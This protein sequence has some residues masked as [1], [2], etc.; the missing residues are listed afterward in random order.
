MGQLK[1]RIVMVAAAGVLAVTSLAGCSRTLNNDAVVA[2]VG[3]DEVKLGVANFYAR[4]Q[5]AQMETYYGSMLGGGDQMWTQEIEEGKTYE[6]STKSN[7]IKS[8]ENMYLLKQHAGDYD[9]ELTDKEKKAID[10][11]ADKFLEDNTL[12]GKDAV[13]GTKKVVKE[14][15]TL[16]T[17]QQKMDAPLKAGVD[18]EVSD[19][20]AA[21]KSMQY[22]LFAYTKQD[23]SGQSADMTD[24]EKAAQKTA[25]QDFAEKLKNSEDKNLET[26]AKAAGAEVQTATFDGESTS[27]NADLVKAADALE[28]EGDVTDAVETDNGIYIAKVTSFLD[29]EATDIKKQ[30]IVE[31]RKQDQYDATIKKWRKATDIKVKK[32]VWKKVSF[33][34]QGVTIKQSEDTTGSDADSGE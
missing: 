20:D 14:Y 33:A 13:S 6:Q 26:A 34:K 22:V 23:E 29:R 27:P 19:E 28:N 31:T 30:S 8:L 1:K 12:E 16:A 18:E 2:T 10:K 4:M 5:Q 9:V 25:A 17:I 3:E 7:V 32:N 15:L 11:A 21:Q 24:D